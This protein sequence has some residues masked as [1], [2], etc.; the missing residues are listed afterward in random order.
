MP[1]K[2]FNVAYVEIGLLE[3]APEQAE[4]LKLYG[5]AKI[6]QGED[7]STKSAPGM[8]NFVA[9]EKYNAWKKLADEGISAADA[10]K[11]YV[12][13]VNEYKTKYGIKPEDKLT[14]EEKEKLA[15]AKA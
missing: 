6:A 4:M 12:E 7:I 2:A 9:K 3:K 8:F 5:L 11:Q 14:A 13:L 10:D 1:S 15:K